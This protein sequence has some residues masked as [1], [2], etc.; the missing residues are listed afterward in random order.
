MDL[1]IFHYDNPIWQFMARVW[2]LMILNL[3]CVLCCLPVLTAGAS[4]TALYYVTLKMAENRESHIYRSFF[5]SFRQNLLQSSAIGLILAGAGA[6]IYIDIRF[7]VRGEA[8]V[9]GTIFSSAPFQVFLLAAAGAV[10]ISYL[11]I[12]MYVFAV[13]ARFANPVKRTLINAFLMAARHLPSTIAI[14][15]IN[16]IFFL[17]LRNYANWLV[18]WMISGPVYINSLFLSKIFKNYMPK[19]GAEE[20]QGYCS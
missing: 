9:A 17:A 1:K 7:F 18:F 11:M 5:K 14:V 13:Q 20:A 19:E 10:T 3:L 2:D 8:L 6:I 15:A 4:V 12:V 16:A